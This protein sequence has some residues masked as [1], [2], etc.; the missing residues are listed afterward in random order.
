MKRAILAALAAVAVV[1]ALFLATRTGIPRAS[2]QI[3]PEAY[4]TDA[5]VPLRLTL[6]FPWAQEGACA[7][8][9]SATATETATRVTVS[10]V[11]STGP[12]PGEAC[13]GIGTNGRTAAVDL[14]LDTP[15][16]GREVVRQTDGQ[17]LPRQG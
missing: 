10:Q 3:T 15:L 4:T 16:G 6:V 8:Q 2:Q 12:G 9:F 14:D 1:M 11:T 13:G 17:T 7:G 5:A